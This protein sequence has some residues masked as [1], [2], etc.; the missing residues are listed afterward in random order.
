MDASAHRLLETVR[1]G[2]IYAVGVVD[3][4][5]G[6]P[7][8]K[9]NGFSSGFYLG[10]PAFWFFFWF[11]GILRRLLV[12]IDQWFTLRRK[13]ACSVWAEYVTGCQKTS[14][15]FLP[16]VVKGHVFGLVI[17]V[18][19]R[20]AVFVLAV[21]AVGTGGVTLRRSHAVGH[22]VVSTLGS[23]IS[24]IWLGGGLVSELLDAYSVA[25]WLSTRGT[26]KNAA[27]FCYAAVLLVLTVPSFPAPVVGVVEFLV[28][29][30]RYWTVGKLVDDP[31]VESVWSHVCPYPVGVK[32]ADLDLLERVGSADGEWPQVRMMA[33]TG[34]RWLKL[35]L[36]SYVSKRGGSVQTVSDL[37]AR[38]Q[39]DAVFIKVMKQRFPGYTK[40]DTLFQGK[41][42]ATLFEAYAG[43][44][45]EAVR[46]SVDRTSAF[47]DQLM[48][49]LVEVEGLDLSD[50]FPKGL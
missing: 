42:A 38:L 11:L 13:V 17:D 4:F 7:Q 44:C 2:I 5:G 31:A 20:C 36:V 14:G 27:R 50:Y 9:S 37:E 34:D 21:L 12:Y 30:E 24:R 15:G 32:V 29:C 28:F 45:F 3:V 18:A 6:G 40:R 49:V 1:G 46:T 8:V 43:V 23:A 26:V 22:L 35:A 25:M 47:Y 48:A 33:M 19:S 41:T 10:H 39:A 16:D